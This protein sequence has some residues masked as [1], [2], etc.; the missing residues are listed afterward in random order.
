MVLRSKEPE[1]RLVDASSLAKILDIS[2]RH[3]ERMDSSGKL[4][5]SL[6]LGRAKRWRL[7]E[8]EDWIEAGC[9]DR[10]TWESRNSER[11]GGRHV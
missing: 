4:P 9:P 10:S 11:E 1:P 5:E 7:P 6:R 3:L 8:I 2:R